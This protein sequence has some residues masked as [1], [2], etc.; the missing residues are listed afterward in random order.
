M[1]CTLWSE[2][3][4]GKPAYAKKTN[5]DR[6]VP[7]DMFL[8][9]GRQCVPCCTNR[10]DDYLI[11]SFLE[12]IWSKIPQWVE[13]TNRDVYEEDSLANSWCSNKLG[14]PICQWARDNLTG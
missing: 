9:L 14:S 12:L 8:L 2:T 13:N 7:E 6:S 11:C 3:L 10:L 1:R 5:N 4:E